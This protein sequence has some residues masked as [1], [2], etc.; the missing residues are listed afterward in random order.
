MPT[1][2]LKKHVFKNFGPVDERLSVALVQKARATVEP[3]WLLECFTADARTVSLIFRALLATKYQQN[4]DLSAALDKLLGNGIDM[5]DEECILKA[6][7]GVKNGRANA[8]QTITDFAISKL[9]NALTSPTQVLFELETRKS[10]GRKAG[11]IKE[12]WFSGSKTKRR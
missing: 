7:Q 1:L 11:W 5:I 4:D 3:G 10:E 8:K 6:F 9:V 12:D 2:D